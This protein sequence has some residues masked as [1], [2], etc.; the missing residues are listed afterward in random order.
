MEQAYIEDAER[1]PGWKGELPNSFH[2]KVDDS[3]GYK[4][5]E[6]EVWRGRIEQL[7]WSPRAYV[8]HNFLSDEECD[9]LISL[10]KGSLHK[11]SVVNSKTG[12]SMD[13]DVRTSSGTFLRQHEDDIVT[14]I[15]KRIA[16][17]TMLPEENGES[18][19]LLRYVDGQKYEPHTDY[20][21]DK[22]N[23]DVSHGGQ[24]IATVLMYLSTPEEGGETVF[25]HAE[26]KVEGDEWS[27]CAKKGLAVKAKRG[28]ALFFYSLKPDGKGDVRST[29][30]SC[31]T[32][33]GEKYSATKWI[34]VG[35]FHVGG[36]VK[37]SSK[38]DCVDTDDNCEEWATIG[39]CD[40]NPEFM[41]SACP[42]S[43]NQCKKK[44]FG[45][46]AGGVV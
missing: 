34:H 1:F 20:F 17:V 33:K 25:P 29:H 26:P 19:Q 31:P 24:R 7:S 40:K 11:S 4:E 21:H 15:E 12:G 18:L 32:L 38:M 27:E 8:L 43:C 46:K 10:G 39:E 45:R 30:G 35:P 2:V 14:A 42:K 23:T 9:H 36:G 28:N 13:S 3:V 22:V 6:N 44:T 41:R 5:G 37:V 16:T